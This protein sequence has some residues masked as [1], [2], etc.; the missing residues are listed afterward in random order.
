MNV[1]E[2]AKVL[3]AVFDGT[4][5]APARYTERVVRRLAR[6][7]GPHLVI[8]AA[9]QMGGTPDRMEGPARLAAQRAIEWAES[10]IARG[11]A[12]EVTS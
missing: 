10:E 5:G 2:A 12:P 4:A 11:A 6:S 8:A 9:D 1:E 7:I 3:R